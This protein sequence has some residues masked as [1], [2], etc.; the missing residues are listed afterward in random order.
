MSDALATYLHDHLAGSNFA[1]ELLQFLREQHR[2]GELANFATGLLKEVEEDR[3]TLEGVMDQ[4]GISRS[5]VKEATAWMGEKLS[6]FKLA[7]AS[8]GEFGTFEALETLALGIQG[9]LSLWRALSIVERTGDRI[10]GIDF[11]MLAARA[12]DQYR[13]VEKQR[14]QAAVTAFGPLAL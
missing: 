5:V 4:A 14:M 2:E 1:V 11:G 10:P 3:Q 13:R 7:H 8:S 6:R 12:E 9:K